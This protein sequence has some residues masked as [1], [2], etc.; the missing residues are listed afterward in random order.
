MKVVLKTRKED[1]KF[2]RIMCK[3]KKD[4]FYRISLIFKSF[5]GGYKETVLFEQNGSNNLGYTQDVDDIKDW[6]D[7]GGEV[8]LSNK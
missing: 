1:T 5:S 2:P 8:I 3:E 7:F 4:E 6:T